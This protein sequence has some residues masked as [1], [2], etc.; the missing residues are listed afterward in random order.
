MFCSTHYLYSYV[1]L[2]VRVVG[3]GLPFVDVARGVEPLWAEPLERAPQEEDLREPAWRVASTKEAERLGSS[4]EQPRFAEMLRVM[5]VG[6]HACYQCISMLLRAYPVSFRI[7]T[8]DEE[9]GVIVGGFHVHD[10]VF[11]FL[12]F[13]CEKQ[14]SCSVFL[15]CLAYHRSFCAGG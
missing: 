6:V 1:Y 8:R 10:P 15:V 3:V 11:P 4:F 2:R 12:V 14:V 5:C 13:F 7:V 9:L